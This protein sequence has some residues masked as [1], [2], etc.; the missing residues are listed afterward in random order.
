MTICAKNSRMSNDLILRTR[1]REGKLSDDQGKKKKRGK[2]QLKPASPWEVTRRGKE[3]PLCGVI[4][5]RVDTK[6]YTGNGS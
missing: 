1:F 4:R 5:C 2:G 3:K 6:R